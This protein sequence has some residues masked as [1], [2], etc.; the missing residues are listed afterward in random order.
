M[1]RVQYIVCLKN[2][3]SKLTKIEKIFNVNFTV[4]SNRQTVGEDFVDF[5]GPLRKH[6]LY[7]K[8]RNLVDNY[9][10]KFRPKELNRSVKILQY[11]NHEKQTLKS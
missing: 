10:I 6:E 3:F 4:C 2:T 8:K 7:K 1:A 11:F 5:C 9:A